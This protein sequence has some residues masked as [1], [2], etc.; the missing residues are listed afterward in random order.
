[1]SFPGD[2]SGKEHQKMQEDITDT[3]SIPGSERSPGIGHSNLFQY[4]CLENPV[5]E[6]PAGLR[7]IG[8]QRDIHN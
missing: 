2:T 7:S 8:S 3:G 4:F 5:T 6:E 1:M